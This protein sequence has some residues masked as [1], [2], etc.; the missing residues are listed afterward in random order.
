MLTS[1]RPLSVVDEAAATPSSKWSG[2]WTGATARHGHGRSLRVAYRLA[3]AGARTC[4]AARSSYPPRH[5]RT[6]TCGRRHCAARTA[7]PIANGG[8]RRASLRLPRTIA[9]RACVRICGARAHW[10]VE[11]PS[12]CNTRQRCG[13]SAA[14]VS[15]VESMYNAASMPPRRAARRVRHFRRHATQ[16]RAA[17]RRAAPRI[18][19]AHSHR[20]VTSRVTSRASHRPP[21]SPA[22]ARGR[23]RRGGSGSSTRRRKPASVDVM[24][25]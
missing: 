11:R 7:L 25:R 18:E 14:R 15:R 1:A 8:A 24:R 21:P 12:P 2:Q 23:R 13:P 6:S 16:G 9:S 5:D 20:R 3:T 19:G 17:R 10:A 22:V 4:A